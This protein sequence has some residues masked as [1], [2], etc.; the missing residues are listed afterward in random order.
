MSAR[1]AGLL[2][3]LLLGGVAAAAVFWQLAHPPH[4][5]VP[6]ALN[7]TRPSLALPEVAPVQPLQLP[8]LEQYGEVLAHPLFIAARRPESPPPEG[9]GSPEKPAAE[10][11]QKPILVGVF[12]TPELTVALLRM[13]GPNAK[14]ARVKPGESVGDWRV[15]TI[16]PDRVVVRKGRTTQELALA[17]PKKPAESRTTRVGHKPAPG[18]VA[19]VPQPPAPAGAPVLPPP[20]APPQPVVPPPPETVE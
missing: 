19:P 1:T 13:E 7:A 2:L 9:E 16:R 10:S 17:R 12:I 15:E 20:G 3:W 14:V 11:E 18:A 8:P 5:P 4:P 6:A